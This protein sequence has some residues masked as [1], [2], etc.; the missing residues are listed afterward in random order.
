[1]IGSFKVN[2]KKDI[3]LK[4]QLFQAIKIHHVF[5]PNLLQKTFIDLLT[6]EVNKLALSVII[7]NEKK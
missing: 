4:L 7:N 1:M 5:H 3:S 2:K 6:S